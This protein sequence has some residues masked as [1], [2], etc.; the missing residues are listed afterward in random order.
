MRSM[1]YWYP[2]PD[3]YASYD[4]WKTAKQAERRSSVYVSWLAGFFDRLD[5]L[6]KK[7]SDKSK[8]KKV[9]LPIRRSKLNQVPLT[10]SNPEYT[11]V[12]QGDISKQTCNKIVL[13]RYC[14]DGKHLHPHYQHCDN[15]SC[16][17]CYPYWAS[18]RAKGI[19]V[20]MNKLWHAYRDLGINLGSPKHVIFS[21]PESEYRTFTLEKYNAKILEYCEMIGIV[22]GVVASPHPYRVDPKIEPAL[23]ACIK[24][25]GFRGGHT[26]AI[27]D[28]ILELGDWRKYYVFSPHYHVVGYMPKIKMK[29]N[30]FHEKTGWVYRN[31]APNDDRSIFK[32]VEYELTHVADVKG[33]QAYRYFGIFGNNKAN[34]K[35]TKHTSEGVCPDCYSENYFLVSTLLMTPEDEFKFINKLEVP[36]PSMLQ[37]RVIYVNEVRFYSV[38]I[39]K[40]SRLTFFGF[41]KEL[42]YPHLSVESDELKRFKK[43]YQKKKRC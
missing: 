29:S 15:K 28:D 36:K 16:P 8:S 14:S 4:K 18:K 3:S 35:K 34:L 2:D 24:A 22:G 37:R 32:T 19:D 31:V 25:E 11:L 10:Y 26:A 27:N 42:S 33:K 17:V 13:W 5:E 12:G 7:Y 23:N 40:T 38:R 20:R 43:K 41:C 9:I 6:V 1:G 30:K 21:I 39:L